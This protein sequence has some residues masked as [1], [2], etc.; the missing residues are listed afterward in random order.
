MTDITKRDY[1]KLTA[2]SL[3]VFTLGTAG[4]V[5]TNGADEPSR[6]GGGAQ[7]VRP[8]NGQRLDY[9][10]DDDGDIE[11]DWEDVSFETRGGDRDIEFSVD[12]NGIELDF[13]TDD[14]GNEVELSLTIDDEAIEFEYDAR[15]N[16]GLGDIEFEAEGSAKKFEN[17]D[18]EVEFRGELI[19]FEWE[20]DTRELDVKGEVMFEFDFDELEYRDADIHIQWKSASRARDAEF[21]A[22]L[23]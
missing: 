8:G 20:E 14:Y 22:R 16:G 21:E 12:I 18:G 5:A 15:A 2:A 1:L 3:G 9:E 13:E 17:E 11:F 10:R 4:L 6:L 23:V 19:H 7:Q